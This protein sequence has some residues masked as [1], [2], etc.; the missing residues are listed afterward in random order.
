V[1]DEGGCEEDDEYD[2]DEGNDDEYDVPEN[3]NVE[4]D[5][6]EGGANEDEPMFSDTG[7][8]TFEDINKQI[9]QMTKDREE[10]EEAVELVE[11]AERVEA[12]KKAGYL[13]P[14]MFE[15][16]SVK[17]SSLEEEDV[18]KV[19]LNSLKSCFELL[20]RVYVYLSLTF[21]F[22]ARSC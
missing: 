21:L 18:E 16:E 7:N 3:E 14:D 1:E 12:A 11:A 15:T 22:C 10:A 8:V 2:D 4:A 9:E 13:V 6:E 5:E 20:N 19:S 17:E